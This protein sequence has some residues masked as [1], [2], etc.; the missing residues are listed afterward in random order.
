[1]SNDKTTVELALA[2]RD[3][4]WFPRERNALT[5]T[6]VP[7][8]EHWIRKPGYVER[9]AWHAAKYLWSR[10]WVSGNEDG[11]LVWVTE[12]DDRKDWKRIADRNPN[13]ATLLA[14]IEAGGKA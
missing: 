10:G 3:F 14:A 7:W 8:H 6:M 2:C 13:D 1:M 4:E 9:I 11:E 5:G 12:S